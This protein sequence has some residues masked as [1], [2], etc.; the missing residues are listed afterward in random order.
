MSKF[1][2]SF[3][4]AINKAV[5]QSSL[6]KECRGPGHQW[7]PLPEPMTVDD[8]VLDLKCSHCGTLGNLALEQKK[9]DA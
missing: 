9:E 1:R 3:G 4:A 8:F 6:I 5:A 2:A 7:T